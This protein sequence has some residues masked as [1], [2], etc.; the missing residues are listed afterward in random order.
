MVSPPIS[1]LFCA[2][3]VNPSLACSIFSLMSL[4][5]W[6]L[7]SSLFPHH[8]IPSPLWPQEQCDEWV[9]S[10][11]AIK[12]SSAPKLLNEKL[13]IYHSQ[14]ARFHVGHFQIQHPLISDRGRGSLLFCRFFYALGRSVQSH[15]VE[16]RQLCV[17]KSSPRHEIM[18]FAALHYCV[19]NCRFLLSSQLKVCRL[20]I[21]STGKDRLGEKKD[22]S[23]KSCNLRDP[24]AVCLWPGAAYAACSHTWQVLR[25]RPQ[26]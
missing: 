18:H 22:G 26:H 13:R 17:E 23:I 24:T 9:F 7:C 8:L 20:V 2:L 25:R 12:Y 10:K 16:E 19:W 15:C 5:N 14:S 4:N 1:L 21:E 6:T 11:K 3:I